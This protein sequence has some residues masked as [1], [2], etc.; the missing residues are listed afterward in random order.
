[1]LLGFYPHPPA[2]TLVA[3]WWWRWW[4]LSEVIIGKFYDGSPLPVNV[5]HLDA[6][7]ESK[8]STSME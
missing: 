3:W 8:N 1:V 2:D 6:I 7:A 5:F 4:R